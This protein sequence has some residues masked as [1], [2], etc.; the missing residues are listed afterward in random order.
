MLNKLLTACALIVT[1]GGVAPAFAQATPD[2]LV[3]QISTDVIASAKIDKSIQ[4]GDIN[5]IITL[6]DAKVMPSV[7]F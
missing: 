1:L 4:A 5:R 7:N 2:G 6:V 3:R